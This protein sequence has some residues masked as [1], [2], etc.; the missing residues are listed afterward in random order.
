MNKKIIGQ[1]L[2]FFL[3]DLM[4][5]FKEGFIECGKSKSKKESFYKQLIDPLTA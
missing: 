5:T 3:E 4:K 2:N 1:N